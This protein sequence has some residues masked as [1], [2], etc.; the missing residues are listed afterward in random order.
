MRRARITTGGQ[1]S[2]PA[3]VR[4]RWGASE[5]LVDDRGDHLIV[6]PADEA[7]AIERA[8]GALPGR[9]SEELRRRARADESAARTRR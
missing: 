2:I 9:S 3:E 8:R 6:R 7:D 4:R 5:V 1:V